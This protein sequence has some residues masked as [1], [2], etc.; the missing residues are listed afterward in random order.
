MD[1]RRDSMR[2]RAWTRSCRS[3]RSRPHG[4]VEDPA[5]GWLKLVRTRATA[6]QRRIPPRQGGVPQDGPLYDTPLIRAAGLARNLELQKASILKPIRC[7]R[8]GDVPAGLRAS[9]LVRGGRVRRICRESCGA[10][11]PQPGFLGEGALGRSTRP[12]SH[13]SAT[14]RFGG[15]RPLLCPYAGGSPD[16]IR[17][18]GRGS[19]R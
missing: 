8:C 7:C 18:T 3:K 6:G 9:H 16:Q 14:L 17:P 2:N 11:S 10:P 5:S 19:D 4:G 12:R 15:E 1:P 13:G